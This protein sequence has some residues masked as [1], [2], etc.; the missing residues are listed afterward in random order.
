MTFVLPQ[1]LLGQGKDLFADQS[2][3]HD[4]DPIL[5]GRLAVGTVAASQPLA[6]PQPSRDA[7]PRT[8]LGLPKARPAPVCWVAPHALAP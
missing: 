7:L 1:L 2:R 6:F 3:N 5:S 4:L 8:E